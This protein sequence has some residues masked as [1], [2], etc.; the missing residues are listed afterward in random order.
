LSP[1]RNPRIFVPLGSTMTGKQFFDGQTAGGTDDVM[2][3]VESLERADIARLVE[4]RP[5]LWSG[6]PDDVRPHLV[7]PGGA[8][9]AR[10]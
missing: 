6:V 10:P 5:S 7:P 1:A 9:K 8:T 2:R 4:S 3:L